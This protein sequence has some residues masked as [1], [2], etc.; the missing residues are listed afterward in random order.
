MPSASSDMLHVLGY[1]YLRF[2]QHRRALAL[3]RIAARQAPADHG[4]MRSLAYALVLNRA[5]EEALAVIERL[6]SLEP[7]SRQNTWLLE[8]RALLLLGRTSEARQAFRHFVDFRARRGR[9]LAVPQTEAGNT[10]HGWSA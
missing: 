3:L 8:S 5:A 2:G 1:L 6:T 10:R 7:A 4:I 9:D